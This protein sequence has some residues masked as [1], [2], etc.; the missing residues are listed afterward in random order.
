MIFKLNYF[1]FETLAM[2]QLVP[3]VWTYLFD[4]DFFFFRVFKFDFFRTMGPEKMVL[5]P[6]FDL[7]FDFRIRV[8]VKI[9]IFTFNIG[10]KFHRSHVK[11]GPGPVAGVYKSIVQS[12]VDDAI[13]PASVFKMVPSGS[14]TECVRGMKLT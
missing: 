9:E 14:S 3:K 7:L 13:D 6:V 5:N 1:I 12:F 11:Y 8:G 4:I 10:V 2:L